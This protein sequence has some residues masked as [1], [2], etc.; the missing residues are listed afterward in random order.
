M[1][2]D[3]DIQIAKAQE[4][5][6]VKDNKI[7]QNIIKRNYTLSLLEQ[8]VLGFF[9]S[10]IKPLKDITDKPQYVYT[11]DVKMF[12]KVCGIDYNNGKNY[13]NIKNIIQQ[14]S[15][16]SFWIENN[17]VKILL[18]WIDSAKIQ[19]HS[20]KISIRFSPEI[21]PYLFDLKEQFTQYELYQILAFKS[22]YSI[23]LYELLKSHAFKEELIISIEDLRHY[24]VIEDKYKEF[25]NLRRRVIEPSIKE[26]ND[27]TNL[28]VTWT[29]SKKGKHYVSL[30]FK[31]SIKQQWDMYEAYRY[32]MAEINGIHHI[33]GQLNLFE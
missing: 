10:L 22:S 20:G 8:K 18:R 29:G 6:I 1:S 16:H 2:F 11:F 31:I 27:F 32:A 33:P 12:C 25:V 3:E 26:I 9:I 5:L 14:L 30:T 4:Q 21:T 23:A 13:A 17:G 19:E 7:I 28:K 15:D 24:L